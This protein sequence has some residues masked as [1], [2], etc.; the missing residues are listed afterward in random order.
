MGKTIWKK[1]Q[2]G[3]VAG[4]IHRPY[5]K[6][7]VAKTE[8]RT[9]TPNHPYHSVQIDLADFNRLKDANKNYRYLF[10]IIDVYSRY[11]WCYPV[12]TKDQKM[13]AGIFEQWLKQ[14]STKVENLT[15]DREFDST[16]FHELAKRYGFTQWYGDI[17]RTGENKEAEKS[18]TGIVERFV[19]TLRRL[20]SLYLT[21]HDTRTYITALPQLLKEY[22]HRQ[23]SSL[24]ASPYEVIT[25][26]KKR[27]LK[28]ERF[29]KGIQM[30][31]H[32]RRLL[33]RRKFAKSSEPYWST[34]IYEVVGRDRNRYMIRNLSTGKMEDRPYAVY[35]LL[36]VTRDTSKKPSLESRQ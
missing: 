19:R 20:I 6:N 1:E 12:Q 30:G 18:R 15:S 22:N 31:T 35:Q 34:E 16:R 32:V 21:S 10:S 14:Q 28:A 4:Q 27:D 26:K 2:G 3:T 9:I 8:F 23:H 36:P 29:V 11:A 24:L 25:K 7:Q 17:L 33:A 5:K 13:L